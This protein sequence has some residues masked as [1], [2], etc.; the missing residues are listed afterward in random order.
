V[1]SEEIRD[2]YII[3]VV[4]SRMANGHVA[5]HEPLVTENVKVAIYIYIYIYMVRRPEV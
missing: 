5:G 4:H 2:F 1:H 3:M